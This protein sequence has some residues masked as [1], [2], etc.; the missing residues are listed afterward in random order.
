MVAGNQHNAARLSDGGV[1][2]W[3]YQAFFESGLPS[4]PGPPSSRPVAR[5]VEA[6]IGA[7]VSAFT[8]S[9][10]TVQAF[11]LNNWGQCNV[12]AL[13]PGTR[14]TSAKANWVHSAALR[15]DGEL[16]LWGDNSYGQ[17]VAPPLAAGTSY[18]G[19]A[20][21]DSF[22]VALRSDGQAFAFGFNSQGQCNVPPPPPGVGYVD[23]DAS[24]VATALLRS[25]GVVVLA[26]NPALVPPSLPPGVTFVD[27]AVGT[28]F[29]TLRSDGGVELW[30]SVAG[31]SLWVPPPPLPFG[32]YYVEAETGM[33]PTVLRRS[34]GEV[35]VC[36]TVAYPYSFLTIVPPL[37]PGT[38][39]V[40]VSCSGGNIGARVGPTCTYVS[41]APG[42]AGSRPATR[43]VPRDTPRIGK[44][45]Q[46]TLFDLPVDVAVL[47][48]GWQQTAPISL[49]S[50][51]M[52]GCNWHTSLDATMAL[53]GQ[54]GQAKWLLPIPDASSL[55][56]I[57]FYNQ[58]VVLD[59]AATGFGAVVSNAAEGVVGRQ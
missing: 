13:P 52:P 36:G 40:Q 53:V 1:L 38:S 51:G 31:G 5:H 20:L 12:P 50:L 57:R 19:V 56:G 54:G 11:G 23:V 34:D 21:G 33:G 3:G 46:V 28:Y 59:P 8:L 16:I 44:T 42:C 24:Q 32:V 27:V 48:M 37:E 4:L 2:T 55:V 29:A 22:T 25:D 26:G 47:A 15:S 35:V 10:G 49:A 9:D 58:A 17:C 41:F 6:S 7:Y 39:Y 43:L 45:L 14:Y 30:G 18:V